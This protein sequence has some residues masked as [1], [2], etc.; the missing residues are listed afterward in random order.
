LPDKPPTQVKVIETDRL[1]IRE[2]DPVRDAEFVFHL[3]NTPK[4]LRYIG[5][6]GVRSAE[7]AGYFI[8]TRYRQSYRDHG[9]GLYCVDLRTG[10]TGTASIGICGFVRRDGLDHPD[11]GFAFLP[12]FEQKGFGCEAASAVLDYGRTTLGFGRVLAVTTLDNDASERLLVKLGFRFEEVREMPGGETLK[13]FSTD[14][15]TAA[16]PGGAGSTAG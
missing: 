15:C 8:E 16:G 3:L 5:D 4:F 7:D 2:L 6:R 10:E 9:F 11:I 13:L 12:E 1:L 14:L